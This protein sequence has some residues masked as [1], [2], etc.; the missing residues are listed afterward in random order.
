MYRKYSVALLFFTLFLFALQGCDS[1]PQTPEE[2]IRRLISVAEDGAEQRDAGALLDLLADDYRDRR[3]NDKDKLAT[4]LRLYFFRNQSI[5][6]L[7]KIENIEFPYQDFARAR[8]IVAMAGQPIA[9]TPAA[10]PRASI[11][12]FDLE[13]TLQGGEW[14]VTGVEWDRASSGDFL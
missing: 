6:L 4:L 13:L 5:H 11:Y 3:G 1:E 8:V 10:L 2:R 14:R 9:N 12:R 7:T